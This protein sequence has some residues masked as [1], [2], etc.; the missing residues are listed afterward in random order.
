MNKYFSKLESD[1]STE[2][3]SRPNITVICK[4]SLSHVTMRK[5]NIVQYWETLQIKQHWPSVP[6]W[7]LL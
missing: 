7:F 4:T 2:F 6:V 3:H 5:N 1:F